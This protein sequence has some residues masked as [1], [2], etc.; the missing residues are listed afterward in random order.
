MHVLPLIETGAPAIPRVP[1]MRCV[2][3]PKTTPRPKLGRFFS[4]I[5]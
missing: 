4:F 3:Q 5:I 1:V 2:H